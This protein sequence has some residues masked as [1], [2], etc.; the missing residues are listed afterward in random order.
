MMKEHIKELMN[1][2]TDVLPFFM[3]ATV[4]LVFAC[5]YGHTHFHPD[6]LMLSC[7]YLP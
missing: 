1:V 3:I 6:T 2:V 5:V 4:F 7:N